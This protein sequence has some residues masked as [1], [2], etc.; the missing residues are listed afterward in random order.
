MV[1]KEEV[2]EEED[3][4]VG[5]V[6]EEEVDMDVDMDVVVD[7]VVDAAEEEDTIRG[8]VIATVA[9]AEVIITGKHQ[10][11]TTAVIGQE[12]VAVEVTSRMMAG[13]SNA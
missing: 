8:L 3:A 1:E 13:K 2:V 9:V 4:V 7:A 11:G 6:A 5:V 10:A 12:E